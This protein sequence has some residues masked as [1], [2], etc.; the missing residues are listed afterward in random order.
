MKKNVF[1]VY[2]HLFLTRIV[3]GVLGDSRKAVPISFYNEKVD[4]I[5]IMHR[6]RGFSVLSL[7]A[8]TNK[9]LWFFC[10][11][12]SASISASIIL[13]FLLIIH[14]SFSF[15]QFIVYWFH[16]DKSSPKS[17]GHMFIYI[18]FVYVPVIDS[19][20]DEIEDDLSRSL[21]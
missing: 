11:S 8:T 20:S 16:K 6:L 21:E 4:V 19:T 2:C 12:L 1:H 7:S 15:G 3:E 18:Y 14:N 10:C 9:Q 17:K 5:C 13:L